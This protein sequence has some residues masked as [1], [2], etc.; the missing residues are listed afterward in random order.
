MQIAIDTF[1][2]QSLE[3]RMRSEV[4]KCQ[5]REVG[6]CW[7]SDSDEHLLLNEKTTGDALEERRDSLLN[8][9]FP[10]HIH[11]GL[12]VLLLSPVAA[13]IASFVYMVIYKSQVNPDRSS[14]G[15]YLSTGSL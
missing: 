8:G 4:R 7:S 1:A 12:L 15:L 13:N 10:R 2:R 14:S 5:P 6:H 11:K 9:F 3:D